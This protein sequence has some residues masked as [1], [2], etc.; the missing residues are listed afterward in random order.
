[1][2]NQQMFNTLKNTPNKQ[3]LHQQPNTIEFTYDH[4]FDENG[5]F[6]YLGS[7]GRKRGW[8]N[9]HVIGALKC[10]ASSI[11]CGHI[12]D[13]VGR[14]VVNCRTLNEPFSFFGVDLG[15][16]RTVLPTCY[17]IRNRNSSTHVLMNWHFEASNDKVN[18]TLLDRR[19]YLSEDPYYNT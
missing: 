5:V 18:W 8:F 11:G 2:S 6:Y 12:E 19:I 3:S 1:M 13:I 15:Q 9:P 16:G 4:D 10:F 7:Q 14:A 17:T